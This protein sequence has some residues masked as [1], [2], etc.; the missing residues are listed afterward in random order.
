[1]KKY[2]LR[3]ILVFI[4]VFAAVLLL[5]LLIYSHTS[6]KLREQYAVETITDI[7]QQTSLAIDYR[8]NNDYNRFVQFLEDYSTLNELNDNKSELNLSGVGIIGFVEVTADEF[9]TAE[10]SYFYRT[11]FQQS[12]YHL[13]NIAFYRLSDALEDSSDTTEYCFFRAGNIVCYFL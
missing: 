7:N 8:L 10:R 4:I 9:I 3:T 11:S 1:M 2:F 5:S 12:Q 6:N 13:Q